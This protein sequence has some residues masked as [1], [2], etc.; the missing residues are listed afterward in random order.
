ME[1]L[2][3]DIDDIAPYYPA[4]GDAQAVQ[5]GLVLDD[6]LGEVVSGVSASQPEPGEVPHY[7]LTTS[8]GRVIGRTSQPFAQALKKSWVSTAGAA[9]GP[10]DLPAHE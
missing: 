4:D 3:S 5:D 6:L 2:N 1:F 10:P 9:N 7:T 8:D